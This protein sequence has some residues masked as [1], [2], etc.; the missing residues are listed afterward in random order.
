MPLLDSA[1]FL[2]NYK[3]LVI[4][5]LNQLWESINKLN[6]AFSMVIL[7]LKNIMKFHNRVESTTKNS[8][9]QH[10]LIPKKLAPF[11]NYPNRWIESNNQSTRWRWP[12]FNIISQRYGTTTFSILY[13]ILYFNSIIQSIWLRNCSLILRT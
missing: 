6:E 2:L 7:T 9:K 1:R 12:T 8:I 4:I 13:T 10:H 5:N 11:G 3:Y